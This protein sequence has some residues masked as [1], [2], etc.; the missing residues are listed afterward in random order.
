MGCRLA[1]Q[2]DIRQIAGD[3]TARDIRHDVDRHAAVFTEIV[4]IGDQRV[5]TVEDAD[6]VPSS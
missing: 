2:Y 5:A 1:D 6:D 4:D 3:D